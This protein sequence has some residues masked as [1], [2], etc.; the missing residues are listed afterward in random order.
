MLHAR[1]LAGVMVITVLACP[2][3]A[4]A[5]DGECGTFASAVAYG[6]GELPEAVAVGDLDG[7]GDL[8]LAVAN[9]LGDDVSILLNHG[10]GTFAAAVTYGVAN[11]P[12][13]VAIGDLDGDLDLDLA[14]ATRGSRFQIA[15]VPPATGRAK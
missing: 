12:R 5:A 7:D 6:A 15:L 1:C 4:V 8:D 11:N 14:V 13:S 3:G 10:D 2:L 9:D